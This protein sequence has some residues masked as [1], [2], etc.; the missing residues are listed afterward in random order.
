VNLEA[1]VC[2][3]KDGIYSSSGFKVLNPR[4]T[5]TTTARD[6]KFTELQRASKIRTNL[7]LS[8]LQTSNRAIA[9]LVCPSQKL[10]HTQEV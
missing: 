10:I 8:L 1:M 7:I 6:E 2:N 4:A 9:K 5:H 3:R